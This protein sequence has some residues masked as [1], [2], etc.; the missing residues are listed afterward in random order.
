[1]QLDKYK[2]LIVELIFCDFMK[3]LSMKYYA[4]EKFFSQFLACLAFGFVT[5]P[6]RN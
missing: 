4:Y 6:T 3:M 2:I 1:M 5:N